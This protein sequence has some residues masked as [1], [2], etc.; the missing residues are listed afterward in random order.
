MPT[1]RNGDHRTDG[2][3]PAARLAAARTAAPRSCGP[4]RPLEVAMIADVVSSLLIDQ[5]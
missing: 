3:E 2:A 4:R 1:H 5:Q